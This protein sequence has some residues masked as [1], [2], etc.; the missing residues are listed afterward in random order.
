MTAVPCVGYPYSIGMGAYWSYSNTKRAGYSMLIHI[1]VLD[2]DTIIEIRQSE[3]I[4][5]M[6]SRRK[7]GR[8]AISVLW[9]CLNGL[10]LFARC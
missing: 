4:K 10:A 7:E 2:I 3:L 6:I 5:A 8:R 1:P 9:R